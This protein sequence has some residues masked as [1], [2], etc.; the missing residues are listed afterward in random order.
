M[1]ETIESFLRPSEYADFEKF[2]QGVE[3]KDLG[4]RV[5]N[6][7]SPIITSGQLDFTITVI[8][9]GQDA[10]A[11]STRK[12]FNDRVGAQMPAGPFESFKDRLGV[13]TPDVILDTNGGEGE[14]YATDPSLINGAIEPLPV[15]YTSNFN[16][17]EVA[18]ARGVR[19]DCE[20]LSVNSRP[21]ALFVHIYEVGDVSS[22]DNAFFDA[23][24]VVSGI[25]VPGYSGIFGADRT[26]FRDH[27]TWPEG[28]V[29][30]TFFRHGSE[31][32]RSRKSAGT[33]FTYHN[34]RYGTDS[35]AFGGLKR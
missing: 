23:Q 19:A 10:G 3:I 16:L 1:S 34:S 35:V 20:A 15:K 4:K 31:F 9:I 8:D 7:N 6:S 27:E 21:S 24:D 33:G 13:L 30:G 2:T 29:A 32:G 22:D 12:P 18:P 28:I 14:I 5:F 26:P 17:A 25:P 11:G